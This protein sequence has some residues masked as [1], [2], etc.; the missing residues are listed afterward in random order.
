MKIVTYLLNLS[1]CPLLF[2]GFE[3]NMLPFILNSVGRDRGRAGTEREQKGKE[4]FKKRKILLER[5]ERR[6][7]E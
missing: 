2:L 4:H 1:T 7:K 3:L 6:E 5:G